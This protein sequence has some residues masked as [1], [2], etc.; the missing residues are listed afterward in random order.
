MSTVRHRVSRGF[1]CSPCARAVIC[2][3]VECIR[4][5][6]SDTTQHLQQTS[7]HGPHFEGVGVKVPQCRGL[8]R[9]LRV[10]PAFAGGLKGKSKRKQHLM[11]G[12]HRFR[13]R[14]IFKVARSASK[15]RRQWQLQR[16]HFGG[17]EMQ[18]QAPGYGLPA[19]TTETELRNRVHMGVS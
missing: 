17:L 12:E 16:P 19:R 14:H 7:H 13:R 2:R 11:L 9:C 4:P 1:S 6:T 8:R 5:F 18:H 15:A 10:N 3:Q